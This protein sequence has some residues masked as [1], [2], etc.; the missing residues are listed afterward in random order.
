MDTSIWTCHQ[1]MGI[2]NIPGT[3]IYFVIM[4]KQKMWIQKAWVPRGNV[5]N[6]FYFKRWVDF[7]NKFEHLTLTLLKLKSALILICQ[8]LLQRLETEIYFFLNLYSFDSNLLY[9]N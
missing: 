7:Y 2:P 6:D 5:K 4:F 8:I 9:L 3:S 1:N